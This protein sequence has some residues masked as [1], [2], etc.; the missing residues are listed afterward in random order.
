[1]A[2]REYGNPEWILIT[3][4][5]GRPVDYN[6]AVASNGRPT[7]SFTINQQ[8]VCRCENNEIGRSVNTP[9]LIVATPKPNLDRIAHKGIEV[10]TPR[11]FFFFF[12][13]SFT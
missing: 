3:G 4:G 2:I 6:T 1:M 7:T 5:T 12:F 13:S 9:C 11:G 8:L 10:G